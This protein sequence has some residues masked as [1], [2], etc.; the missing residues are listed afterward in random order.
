MFIFI[1]KIFIKIFQKR[2]EKNKQKYLIS[3]LLEAANCSAVGRTI[4]FVVYFLFVK[5][6]NL[7][8][9]YLKE[10]VNRFVELTFDL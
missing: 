4:C 10:K 5:L 3:W 7:I 9:T 1:K 6:N 8:I 2:K